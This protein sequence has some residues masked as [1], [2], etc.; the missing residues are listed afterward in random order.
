M[1]SQD[2]NTDAYSVRVLAG[3]S[4]T[5]QASSISAGSGAFIAGKGLIFA[6]GTRIV[7]SKDL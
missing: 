6:A 1:L 2:S 3:G 4:I 5:V 7:M